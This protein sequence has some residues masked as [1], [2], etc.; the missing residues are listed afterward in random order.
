VYEM[1]LPENPESEPSVAL[2]SAE[3]NEVDASLR[4][5]ATLTDDPELTDVA[6]TFAVG[7]VV[8][9]VIVVDAEAADAGP[10]FPAA[11][12]AP[13]IAN[14]GVTVPSLHPDTVTVRLLDEVSVPGENEHPV[15]EP[16]FVKS[17]AATPVTASENDN[18]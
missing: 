4:L 6:V 12:D 15:A 10:V 1:P 18:V 3:A 2:T 14:C 7:A 16:V 17:A 9:R 5:I 8:S 13:L 11:S